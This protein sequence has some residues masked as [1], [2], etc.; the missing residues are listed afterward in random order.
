MGGHD[1]E[2]KVL[3]LLLNLPGNERIGER[4]FGNN[5]SR[6]VLLFLTRRGLLGKVHR[7]R[8][9]GNK[10]RGQ[11]GGKEGGGGWEEFRHLDSAKVEVN[12]LEEDIHRHNVL[13]NQSSSRRQ[14]MVLAWVKRG[15]ETRKRL[16]YLW[17]NLNESLSSREAAMVS[18][19]L[20]ST[21]EGLESAG[22][23]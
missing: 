19:K 20:V 8:G 14:E 2:E 21:L 16:C 12:N 22:S 23:D 13:L 18:K 3:L 15:Q 6:V 17:R 5:S 7:G 11:H 4:H 10:L 1:F 9:G